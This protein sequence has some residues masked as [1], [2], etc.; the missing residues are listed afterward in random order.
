MWYEGS[1]PRINLAK[2]IMAERKHAKYLLLPQI[3]K[4]DGKTVGY[5]WFDLEKGAYNSFSFFKTP[6]EAIDNYEDSYVF[7][8]VDIELRRV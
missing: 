8:N 7:Y 6:E 3:Q 5:N 2:P 1:T 4:N